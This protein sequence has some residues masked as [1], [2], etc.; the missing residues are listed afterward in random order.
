MKI[1][2]YTPTKDIILWII[3]LCWISIGVYSLECNDTYLTNFWVQG[4]ATMVLGTFAAYVGTNALF[5]HPDTK[6]ARPFWKLSIILIFLGYSWHILD[7][8]HSTI[9]LHQTKEVLGM[10]T[11]WIVFA[12]ACISDIR[13]INDERSSDNKDSDSEHE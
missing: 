11:I 13:I 3:V 7:G 12:G 10:G 1:G 6:L 8:L 2:F 4:S 5:R 9:H